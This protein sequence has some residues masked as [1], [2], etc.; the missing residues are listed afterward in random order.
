VIPEIIASTS[1]AKRIIHE[2]SPGFLYSPAKY[3]R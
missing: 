1:E 3:I 2:S